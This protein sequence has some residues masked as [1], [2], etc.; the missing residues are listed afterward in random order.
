MSTLS[1]QLQYLLVHKEMFLHLKWIYVH[2]CTLLR[3]RGCG[4]PSLSTECFS[5]L[6]NAWLLSCSL[7]RTFLLLLLLLQRWLLSLPS[8]DLAHSSKPSCSNISIL[9][10]PQAPSLKHKIPPFWPPQIYWHTS[11]VPLVLS[12]FCWSWWLLN[13]HI[14]M[15]F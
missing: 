13:H 6:R 5:E 11:L 12:C 9:R 10:S 14:L 2:N 4:L 7:N 1:L 15:V 8:I 3:L